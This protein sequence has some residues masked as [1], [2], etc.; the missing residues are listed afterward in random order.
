MLIYCHM[1]FAPARKLE[2]TLVKVI[3]KRIFMDSVFILFSLISMISLHGWFSRS[4]RNGFDGIIFSLRWLSLET[5]KKRTKK[6][7]KNSLDACSKR[8]ICGFSLVS[9]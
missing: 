7:T 2:N 6:K 4:S 3:K 9:I 8:F 5:N 1:F